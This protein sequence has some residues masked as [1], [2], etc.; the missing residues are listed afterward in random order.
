MLNQEVQSLQQT[1]Q[2]TGSGDIAS[3]LFAP[4]LA[5]LSLRLNNTRNNRT[6]SNNKQ[7]YAEA[8]VEAE[9]EVEEQLSKLGAMSQRV[10]WSI[11]NFSSSDNTNASNIHHT[12]I[13]LLLPSLIIPH[14][15][16][17][18]QLPEYIVSC[19]SVTFKIILMLAQNGKN[20]QNT[21]NHTNRGVAITAISTTTIT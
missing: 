8:E 2:T 1:K 16:Q 18:Q 13:T 10:L 9:V 12:I 4:L 3:V 5:N 14:F 7:G 19:V 15:L 21:D 6:S 20:N 17:A 11:A